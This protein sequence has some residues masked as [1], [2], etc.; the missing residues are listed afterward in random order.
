MKTR[1]KVPQSH[2]PDAV[3]LFI[4]A[5]V[6][7]TYSLILGIPPPPHSLRNVFISLNVFIVTSSCGA[8]VA[9]AS[10]RHSPRHLGGVLVCLLVC[11]CSYLQQGASTSSCV[12][13]LEEG[14]PQDE[15][16]GAFEAM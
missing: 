11:L 1:G 7:C 3:A 2:Y 4:F 13:G 9:G 16:L 8:Q 12:H 6:M 5:A 14:D 10:A 15:S